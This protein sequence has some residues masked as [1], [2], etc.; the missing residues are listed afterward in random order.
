MEI[1][2]DTAIY[3]PNVALFLYPMQLSCRPLLTAHCRLPSHTTSVVLS[4]RGSEKTWDRG[5]PTPTVMG[6]YFVKNLTSPEPDV[7]LY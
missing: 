6:F 2:I 3:W 5:R 7:I 1:I 4:T